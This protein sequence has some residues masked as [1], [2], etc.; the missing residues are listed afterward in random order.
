MLLNGANIA[1]LF[2]EQLVGK[3]ITV[4]DLK[5]L[6]LKALLP[7][8]VKYGGRVKVVNKLFAKASAAIDLMVFGNVKEV[9][10]LL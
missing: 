9:I 6:L 5:G 1:S 4:P 7:K 8:L 2:Q 10:P 3:I